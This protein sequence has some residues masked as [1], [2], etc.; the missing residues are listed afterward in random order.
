MKKRYYISIF[1]CILLSLGLVIL[2]LFVERQ[3]GPSWSDIGPILALL[4]SFVA[5]LVAV[6]GRGADKEYEKSL[7]YLEHSLSGFEKAHSLVADGNNKRA[8]C[9]AA[10]RILEKTRGLSEKITVKDHKNIYDIELDYWRRHFWELLNRLAHFFYGATDV[11]IDLD[12]AAKQSTAPE[13]HR[14]S[15]LKS[16]PEEVLFTIYNVI[17][18]PDD[19][20]ETIK[21]VF[22]NDDIPKIGIN[23]LEEYLR[24][25]RQYHSVAGK[26]YPEKKEV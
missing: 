2:P 13:T 11:N 26:L 10:A 18:Y 15:T 17:K 12:E 25:K 8:N 9:V 24:H 16:I 23:G 22:Q 3:K 21:G 6:G 1:V 14:L 20:E 5:I 19:Y 4:A 7:F